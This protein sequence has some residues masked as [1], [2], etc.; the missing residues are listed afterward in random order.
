[1]NISIYFEEAA[2]VLIAIEREF[3]GKP[4]I[5]SPNR[6]Y[7]GVNQFLLSNKNIKSFDV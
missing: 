5:G 3:N 1:V 7:D 2:Q 4:S 6:N